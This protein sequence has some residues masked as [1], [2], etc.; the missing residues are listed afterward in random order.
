MC[1]SNRKSGAGESERVLRADSL[2]GFAAAAVVV[3]A[4]L[5]T[6]SQLLSLFASAQRLE[7]VAGAVA[8]AFAWAALALVLAVVAWGLWL[9]RRLPN[10]PKVYAADFADSPEAF[11]AVLQRG[12][13][14][15]LG[16][17]DEYARRAGFDEKGAS[18]VAER[19]RRLRA[20]SAD[21]LRAD[22]GYLDWPAAM[23]ILQ[24]RQD[25][26]AGEIINRAMGL[27]AV[28]TAASPWKIV[29]SL[30]VFYV[31]A[32]M[33]FDI[34][35]VYNRRTTRF[36][37]LRLAGRWA[38]NIYVAR[39]MSGAAESGVGVVTGAAG[40]LMKP[41]GISGAIASSLPLVG[42]IASKAVEG[43][44]NAFFARS[45]GKRAIREFQPVAF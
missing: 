16:D 29:D 28:K 4:V 34:A 33:I 13:L 10:V 32:M 35:R 24:E 27:I 15:R 21:A 19:I 40:H 17:A 7:G 1:K 20:R 18:E 45:L 22:D 9:L 39:E 8:T 38:F 14:A 31:S 41:N 26:R 3:A 44:A 43:G 25:E 23:R 12:Y 5:W 6:G 37:A 30:A 36:G 11:R 2:L 42:K